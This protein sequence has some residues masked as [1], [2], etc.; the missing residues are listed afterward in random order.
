[1]RDLTDDVHPPSGVFN[2]NAAIVQA[3]REHYAFIEFEPD[4]T[5]I[6][7]NRHFLAAVGYTNEEIAGRHHRIFM[8]P[9]EVNG[10][11]YREF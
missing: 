8:P 10:P 5:I 11:E 9:D 4:G 2:P 7:A 1:M 3:I 6:G